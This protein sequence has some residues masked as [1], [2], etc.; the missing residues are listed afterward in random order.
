M[1]IKYTPEEFENAKSNDLLKLQ[2]EY[3]GEIFMQPKKTIAYELS[4]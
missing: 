4:Q 2:C 1:I 3:C